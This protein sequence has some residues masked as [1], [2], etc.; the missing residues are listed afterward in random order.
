MARPRPVLVDFDA[1]TASCA[2]NLRVMLLVIGLKLCLLINSLLNSTLESVFESVFESEFDL[3]ICE[4]IKSVMQFVI[5]SSVSLKVTL[6]LIRTILLIEF[7]SLNMV[8]VLYSINYS[9]SDRGVSLPS[10]LVCGL[11]AYAAYLKILICL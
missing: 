4:I 10:Y 6:R 2:V 11:S 8:I 7:H 3:G 1:F 5:A 9:F